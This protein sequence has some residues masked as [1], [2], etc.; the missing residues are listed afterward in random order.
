MQPAEPLQQIV[1]ANGFTGENDYDSDDLP[2][3]PYPSGGGEAD[4][5][6]ERTGT[7]R[8]RRWLPFAGRPAL[9][10]KRPKPVDTA[11]GKLGSSCILFS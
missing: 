2:K 8:M 4:T 6:G 3:G 5:R 9:G 1:S 7:V 10:R 11:A